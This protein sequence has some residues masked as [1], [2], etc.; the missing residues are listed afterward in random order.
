MNK[1]IKF[2][3]YTPENKKEL[4]NYNAIFLVS[5]SGDD[6]YECQNSFSEN[7]LKIMYDAD[8]VVRSLSKDVSSFFPIEMSVAEI[9][10][11]PDGVDIN[12][13][14]VFDGESIIPRV[15]TQVENIE[16][17]DNKK[18]FLLSRINQDV[19]PLQDAVDLG[20]ASEEEEK[21]LSAWKK[22][23]VLLMRL[24]TSKAPDIEWPEEPVS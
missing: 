18:K 1:F 15:Y 24:D 8:N 7:T 4:S 2:K 21:K 10:D 12:G 23:R 13:G 5:D 17:A 3:R 14:W 19:I 11:F 22:Y 20:I 9:T 6:W 16:M